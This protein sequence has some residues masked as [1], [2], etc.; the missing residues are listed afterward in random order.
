M[1]KLVRCIKD[2]YT[3]SISINYKCELI[4]EMM[5]FIKIDYDSG[6]NTDLHIYIADKHQTFF[7]SKTMNLSARIEQLDSFINQLLKD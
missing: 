4:S 2:R 6:E 5:T 1:I 3:R 7:V